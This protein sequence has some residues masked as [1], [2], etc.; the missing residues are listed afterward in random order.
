MNRIWGLYIDF[1]IQ[2]LIIILCISALVWLVSIWLSYQ[3]SKSYI[4]PKILLLLLSILSVDTLLLQPKYKKLKS[5]SSAVLFTQ[6]PDVENFDPSKWN[7]KNYRFFKL[8]HLKTN[9]SDTSI[10]KTVANVEHLIN[11][12]QP[13]DSILIVGGQIPLADLKALLVVPVRFINSSWDKS[14]S[15]LLSFQYTDKVKVSDNFNL[16]L[17]LE[18]D[19]TFQKY[20]IQSPFSK[21]DTILSKENPLVIEHKTKCAIPGNHLVQLHI[22]KENNVIAEEIILPVE[23]TSKQKANILMLN[24]HPGFEHK[25]LK[26]WIAKQGHQL[27]VRTQVSLKNYQFDWINEEK[28]KS[29]NINDALLKTTDLLIIDGAALVALTENEYKSI[30]SAYQKR[31]NILL[32][33]DEAILK[34]ENEWTQFQI[35]IEQIAQSKRLFANI[36]LNNQAIEVEIHPY[37]NNLFSSNR[38]KGKDAGKILSTNRN[39]NQ[40]LGITNLQNTYLFNLKGDTTIYNALWS[41]IIDEMAGTKNILKNTWEIKEP[42]P[43]IGH[44]TEVILRT[45]EDEPKAFLKTPETPKTPKSEWSVLNLRQHHLIAEQYEATFWAH[46]EGWYQFKTEKDSIATPI[47]IAGKHQNNLIR[48]FNDNLW[49]AKYIQQI[50]KRDTSIYRPKKVYTTILIPPIWNWLIFIISL[51]AIWILDK[52]TND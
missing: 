15:A 17:E 45:E 7:D 24:G 36:S 18:S 27:K 8:P 1:S 21:T 14:S 38:F 29:F 13:L 49:K 43:Q 32:R 22:L 31:M 48:T 39:A 50:Q 28:K 35:S 47:Y 10:L 9:L 16:T 26:N 37:Q 46:N 3:K 4:I 20:V 33:T 34:A 6:Q 23:V 2:T 40:L 51:S 44:S 5:V 41:G 52:I 19:S 12:Y 42:Y 25:Q 11:K 30:K